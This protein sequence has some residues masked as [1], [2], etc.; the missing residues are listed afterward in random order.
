MVLALAGKN[1]DGAGK[2][3]F[4]DVSDGYN[5]YS[6][7]EKALRDMNSQGT[8]KAGTVEVS[9]IL[10]NDVATSIVINDKNASGT[11]VSNP[12]I[13]EGEF[14]PAYWN[15]SSKEIELRYYQTPMTDSEIKNA[16]ADL[17]GEPVARLNKLL[18]FV[19]MENGDMYPVDFTQKEVVAISVDGD[20]VA[21]TD[22]GTAVNLTGLPA[23][24]YFD[25]NEN[26]TGVIGTPQLN[27]RADGKATVNN[28][29]KDREFVTAYEVSYASLSDVSAKMDNAAGTNVAT[30]NYVAAD[31]DI[32]LTLGN[33]TGSA[34]TYKVTVDDDDE[35]VTV[36]NGMSETMS[37]AVTG[38]VEVTTVANYMT[39][40]DIEDVVDAYNPKPTL[41][42]ATISVDG[43][44]LN[45]VINNGGSIAAVSGTGL[46]DLAESLLVDNT[47]LVTF[48][49]GQAVRLSQGSN[50]A[51]VKTALTPYLSQLAT[52]PATITVTV[53]NAASGASVEYTVNVSEAEA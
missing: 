24:A 16:I 53:Q 20:V 7:L 6:G 42:G 31:E 11:G 32:V 51:A 8:F 12:S 1:G 15:N 14:A 13:P 37:I 4:D 26:P 40:G 5:G 17:L 41:T 30:G 27:V 38:K 46:M 10:E 21:Y 36:A 29:S 43:D 9:A 34:V 22:K 35:F 39:A 19:E 3:W 18:G 48:P 25:I 23:G 44:T 52:L 45:L 33:S 2:D 28:T 47:I 50:D 49:D